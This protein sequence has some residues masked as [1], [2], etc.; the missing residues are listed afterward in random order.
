MFG[1]GKE[2][3]CICN[4]NDG[5]KKIENGMI[6]KDC[7]SKCD[8]FIVALNWKKIPSEQINQ[9]I[10]ANTINN[11]YLSIFNQTKKIEKYISIDENNQ[12]WKIPCFSKN[13]VFSYNDIIS[14]ELLQDG[15]TI[16]KGG[17]GSAVAGGV[18]F[19][20]VGAMVGGMV[21]GKKSKQEIS[22]YRIKIVT[23][24]ACYPEVYI[25]FLSTGKVKSNSL[26]FKSY[27]SNAERIL[28]LLTV[29]TDAAKNTANA[30]PSSV[31]DELVKYKE[32]LDTGIISQEEF[33]AKKKQLLQL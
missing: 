27:S 13:L 7:I 29:I 1:K 16:T 32:L 20:G 19:G 28:S 23:R 33:D 15:E 25:N 30:S 6:C 12:L 18:L 17:L 26:L 24:N 9:A 31:P 21:G 8:P 10:T 22:E 14:Y 4:Q 5:N 11:N 3:C 2:T